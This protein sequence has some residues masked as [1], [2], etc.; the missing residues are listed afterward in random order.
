MS[1]KKRTTGSLGGGKYFP[2]KDEFFDK[3]PYSSDQ[4]MYASEEEEFFYENTKL[5][6]PEGEP[7][8]MDIENGDVVELVLFNGIYWN[9]KK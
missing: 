7:I 9:P 8:G 1:Y 2:S 6:V 5:P 3:L 4:I